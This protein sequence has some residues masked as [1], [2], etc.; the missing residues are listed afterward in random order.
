MT[1]KADN[2]LIDYT[3]WRGAR[4]WRRIYPLSLQFTGELDQYHPRQWVVKAVDLDKKEFR[5]FALHNIHEW[6]SVK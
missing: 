3:N 4:S 2:V 5:E 1:E 6:K